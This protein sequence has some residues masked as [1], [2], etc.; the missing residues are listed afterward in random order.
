MFQEVFDIL[1]YQLRA[2][3]SDSLM[4]LGSRVVGHRL[5]LIARPRVLFRRERKESKTEV[6][7]LK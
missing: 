3:S 6:W 5:L 2:G 4:L 7:S 1:Q